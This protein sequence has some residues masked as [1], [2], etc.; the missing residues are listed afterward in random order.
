MAMKSVQNS[1][2]SR[3]FSYTL[4]FIIRANEAL[5]EIRERRSNYESE[6]MKEDENIDLADNKAIE[7]WILHLARA[8]PRN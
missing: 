2:K 5:N 3:R 7:F 6:N 8:Y 4:L 1:G